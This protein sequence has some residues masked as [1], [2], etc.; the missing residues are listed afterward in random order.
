MR[1]L[2]F[3]EMARICEEDLIYLFCHS[4]AACGLQSNWSAM[5]NASIYGSSPGFQDHTNSYL[6]ANVAKR[7]QI[8][9]VFQALPLPIQNILFASFADVNMNEPLQ[10]IFKKFSGAAC[11]TPLADSKT[12]AAA[13]QRIAQGKEQKGDKQ[14]MAQVRTL[15]TKNY[16]DAIVQY[17]ESK[18][19]FSK[20][21]RDHV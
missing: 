17:M 15:A 11:C 9:K 7:R 21:W 3:D 19:Q 5:V 1:K 20:K 12:L 16:H 8:E 2:S 13:C 6:L 10:K 14:L 4:E 18:Y